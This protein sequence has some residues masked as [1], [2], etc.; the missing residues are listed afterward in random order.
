MKNFIEMKKTLVKIVACVML[1]TILFTGCTVTYPMINEKGTEAD[2]ENAASVDATLENGDG[3]AEIIDVGNLSYEDVGN[4]FVDYENDY[5]GNEPEVIEET[6]E[7]QEDDKACENGNHSWE[8]IFE[9]I[10]SCEDDGIVSFTCTVCGVSDEPI[11]EP[12]RHQMIEG[13]VVS[14]EYYAGES[15]KPGVSL[16]YYSCDF[17]GER[18]EET[19]EY[20]CENEEGHCPVGRDYF[21]DIIEVVPATAATCPQYGFMCFDC[22][23]VEHFYKNETGNHNFDSGNGECSDC[24]YKCTHAHTMVAECPS[25]GMYTCMVCGYVSQP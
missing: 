3:D 2:V 12:A 14:Q 1:V 21:G 23:E 8:P 20:W 15:D 13:R 7:A 6:K 17:C 4:D 16:Y 22:K 11:I 25:E 10:R 19:F 18:G 24:G 9:Q 5:T